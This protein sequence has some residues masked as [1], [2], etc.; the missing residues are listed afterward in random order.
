[1]NFDERVTNSFV[2]SVQKSM[3]KTCESISSE[4]E[5]SDFSRS[6]KR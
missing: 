6:A 1:M 4:S 5:M 3:S 2:V